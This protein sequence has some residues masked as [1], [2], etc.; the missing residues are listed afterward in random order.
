MAA[1]S[2]SEGTTGMTTQPQTTGPTQTYPT[3]TIPEETT[4]KMQCPGNWLP[5]VG[6]GQW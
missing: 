1:T 5:L 2:Q 3:T 6:N 4:T